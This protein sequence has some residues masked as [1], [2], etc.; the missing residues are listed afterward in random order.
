MADVDQS[1]LKARVD[2]C[3][4]TGAFTWK[5]HAAMPQSWNTRWTGRPA[6]NCREG[7][8]YLQGTIDRKHFMAHRIAWL[9]FHGKWPHAQIDHINGDRTDNKIS[10][11]REVTNQ[12]NALNSSRHIDNTSGETG[13]SFDHKSG[14]WH[15]YLNLEG[16]RV[17]NRTYVLR[18]E[19]VQA[20]KAAERQYGFHPNH[21]RPSRKVIPGECRE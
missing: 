11:L 20:R 6:F 8:G 3:P 21:G 12:E 5:A 7:K 16:K 13:V 18:Q 9:W 1:Y 15:A 10:N 17:F 14:R 4:D 2:Y 19:A